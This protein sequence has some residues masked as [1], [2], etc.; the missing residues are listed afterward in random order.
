MPHVPVECRRG[1][2][3]ACCVLHAATHTAQAMQAHL[4][5]VLERTVTWLGYAAHVQ[6]HGAVASMSGGTLELDGSTIA[7]TESTT[8]RTVGGGRGVSSALRR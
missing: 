6:D 1:A 5:S 8:V 2:W 4:L 3:L 7:N